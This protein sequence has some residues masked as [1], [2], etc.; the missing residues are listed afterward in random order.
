MRFSCVSPRNTDP[1][2]ASSKPLKYANKTA[3]LAGISK[4]IEP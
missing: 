2:T 4:K 1:Q 3:K